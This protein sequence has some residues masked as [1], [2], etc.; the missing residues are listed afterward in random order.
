MQN[1]DSNND[2]DNMNP[3]IKS[4][5]IIIAG[6]EVTIDEKYAGESTLNMFL[7]YKGR[8]FVRYHPFMGSSTDCDVSRDVYIGVEKLQSDPIPIAG[9]SLVFIMTILTCKLL[10]L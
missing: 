6:Q 3:Q 1:S 9:M 4:T 7:D 8:P 10:G 5:K 2:K